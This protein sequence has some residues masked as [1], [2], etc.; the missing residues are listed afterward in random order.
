[1][2]KL[3]YWWLFKIWAGTWHTRDDGYYPADFAESSCLKEEDDKRILSILITW[4]AQGAIQL[5]KR[6]LS[7][8]ISG[9]LEVARLGLYPVDNFRD[10][11]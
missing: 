7:D 5:C 6:A 4:K 1:M 10:L 11:G 3:A 9:I 8:F 2:L